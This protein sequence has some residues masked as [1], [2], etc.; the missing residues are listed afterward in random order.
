VH[1]QKKLNTS[2][3]NILA[4]STSKTLNQN[5]VSNKTDHNV[6]REMKPN[7]YSDQHVFHSRE[8]LNQ[9]SSDKNNSGQLASSKRKKLTEYVNNAKKL[10][11]DI[12]KD[13]KT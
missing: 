8:R 5:Y 11:G 12:D 6:S 13:L 7:P 1:R 2:N 9:Q 10:E 4:N 3:S